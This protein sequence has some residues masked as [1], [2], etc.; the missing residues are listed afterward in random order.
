MFSKRTLENLVAFA[1]LAGLFSHAIQAQSNLLSAKEHF[2]RAR[3]YSETGDPR[4]EQE[5]RQA[6]A[7]RKGVYAEAWEGLS[8]HL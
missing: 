2:E 6:I 7:D 5:Y 3:S 4:A 1:I 8:R